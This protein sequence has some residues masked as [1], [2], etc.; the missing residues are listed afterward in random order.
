MMEVSTQK[1]L[2]MITG[3]SRGYGL[4]L[5]KAAAKK[6]NFPAHF[7]LI[8]RSQDGL[9]KCKENVEQARSQ[10]CPDMETSV[11]TKVLDLQDIDS[12]GSNLDAL[13]NEVSASNYCRG[14]LFSNAGIIGY[15][16]QTK[17]AGAGDPLATLRA[18]LDVNVVAAAMLTARFLET[19]AAAAAPAAPSAGGQEEEGATQA[20]AQAVAA[21]GRTPP[22]PSVLVGT[23]S[24]C[25]VRPFPTLAAY[26]MSKAAMDMMLGCAAAEHDPAVLK[27]LNWAPGPL[28]G[29]D[30]TAAVRAAAGE[31]GGLHP[32]LAGFYL[33]QEG[34]IDVDVSASA[35]MDV[36]LNNEFTSGA[37]IDVYDVL[38]NNDVNKTLPQKEG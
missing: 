18:T 30:M 36:L 37:H 14:I 8:A 10:H 7:C 22:P 28:M 5:A 19:F 27:V 21:A 25:A 12:L 13:F 38:P 23:S 11:E 33:G 26:C 17:S 31:G 20:Q 29:T 3:A 34:F 4:A 24:L 15:I 6:F 16:G 35:C 2:V 32:S 1:A 9:N